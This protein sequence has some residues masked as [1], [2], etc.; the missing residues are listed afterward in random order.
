MTT[1]QPAP[2]RDQ[3]ADALRAETYPY[4]HG[5]VHGDVLDVADAVLPVVE[6]ETAAKD[7]ELERLTDDLKWARSELAKADAEN[8]AA[9]KRAVQAER[10]RDAARVD[11]RELEVLRRDMGAVQ[12]ERDDYCDAA[13]TARED[14]RLMRHDRDILATRLEEAGRERDEALAAADRVR[15]LCA[16]MRSHPYT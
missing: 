16:R 3:I 4:G 15:D 6:A 11:R 7:A 14:A 1:E 13:G 2:L 9:G 12:A 5:D 8:N 10:Q